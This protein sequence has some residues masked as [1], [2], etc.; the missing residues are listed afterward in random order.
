M[1][2]LSLEHTFLRAALML[3]GY[4]A[5]GVGAL[6]VASEHEGHRCE[7]MDTAIAPI[8]QC[9]WWCWYGALASTVWNLV[10]FILRFHCFV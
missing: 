10:I 7:R 4:R 9:R 3:Q 6:G 8:N 5:V 2:H 1:L